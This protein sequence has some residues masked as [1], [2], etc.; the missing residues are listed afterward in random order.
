MKK[1]KLL[2]ASFLGLLLLSGCQSSDDKAA[3]ATAV[4][5]LLKAKSELNMAY[6]EASDTSEQK[7]I[8]KMLLKIDS[9]GNKNTT[10][11]IVAVTDE[12][13]SFMSKPKTPPLQTPKAEKKYNIITK[14][15]MNKHLQKDLPKA[16]DDIAI[17]HSNLGDI[18]IRFFPEE[19]PK[20]VENF[21]GLAKKGYYDGVIFHRI[22]NGFMLQG[23]DPTGT[24]MGGESLWGGK[25][26]DEFSSKVSNLPYSVSMAN[27]G[28]GT[29]GSQFFINQ[30]SN[31]FLDGKHSVFGEVLLGTNVVEAIMKVQTGAQDRPVQ[32]VVMNS[33]EIV[34]YSTIADKISQ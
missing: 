2:L 24:G 8:Q 19:A 6:A 21:V 28:P 15:T 11:E 34:P 12:V 27:A 7:E 17:I 26:A 10:E 25:F 5:D 9:T 32:D 4:S 22:I 13:K 16:D 20:T 29:N 31:T 33:V 14:L 23:G 30:G 3:H 1:V 18:Y